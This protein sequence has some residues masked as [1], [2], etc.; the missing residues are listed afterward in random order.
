[1]KYTVHV[2]S[3]GSTVIKLWSGNHWNTS[4]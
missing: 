3:I 1:M 2:K 4:E